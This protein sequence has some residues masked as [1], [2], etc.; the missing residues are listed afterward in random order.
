VSLQSLSELWDGVTFWLAVIGTA[1]LF[2][3]VITGIAARGY[4]RRLSEERIQQAEDQKRGHEQSLASLRLDVAKA[5]AR[6]TEAKEK[7]AEL[8]KETAEANVRAAEATLE[9]Q[10]LR[11]K[12]APRSLNQRDSMIKHLKL[13]GE[14]A[15]ADV[16]SCSTTDEAKGLTIQIW[17]LLG[18]A[19]WKSTLSPTV[20]A[21]RILV[22]V[23][24]ESDPNHFG[25]T[26]IAEGLAEILRT[27]GG[28]QAVHESMSDR[29]KFD[30]PIR[31]TVGTQPL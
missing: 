14:W 30:E 23:L 31:I 16:G 3:S 21:D 10:K 2:V 15:R 11:Q 13:M 4:G 26:N 28:V 8:G 25:A 29:N 19:G 20:R 1:L 6:T 27:M 12:L 5:D 24:V 7:I 18:D 22:G 9:L 17:R